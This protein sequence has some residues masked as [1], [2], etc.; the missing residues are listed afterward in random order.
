MRIAII[1]LPLH[2][3]YGG[4]LQAYAL[5]NVLK[6]MGHTVETIQTPSFKRIPLWRKPLTYIKRFILKYIFGRNVRVFF[7]QWYNI[8]DPSLVKHMKCFI[9]EYISIRLVSRYTD[10]KEDEYEAFIVGSDQIW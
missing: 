10:I 1:T 6:Q 8:T 5:Q 4:I 3:N 2:A 9:E 7:E